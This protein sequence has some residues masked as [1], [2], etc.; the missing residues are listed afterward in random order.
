MY[1]YKDC[2][3]YKHQNMSGKDTK[4]NNLSTL[5]FVI[6]QATHQVLIQQGLLTTGMQ[7]DVI[8]SLFIC[9]SI[10]VL[11]HFHFDTNYIANLS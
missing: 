8:A 6:W 3:A 2:G 5:T 4:H 10:I 9:F 11:N 7:A 1:S